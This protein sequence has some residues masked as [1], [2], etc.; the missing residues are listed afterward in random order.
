MHISL[1]KDEKII[2]RNCTES[3]VNTKVLIILDNE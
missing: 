2:K 3:A 1:K